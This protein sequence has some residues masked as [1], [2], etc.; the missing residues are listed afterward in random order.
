M[1]RI[2]GGD[3]DVTALLAQHPL[4]GQKVWKKGEQRALKG[5]LHSD[6]GASVI[7]S[8]ADFDQFELQVTEATRFLERYANTLATIAEYPGVEEMIFDFGIA[9]YEGHVMMS[10]YLPPRF[11]ELAAGAGIGIVISHYA[12]SN[13]DDKS[14]G[15]RH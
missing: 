8:E 4:P 13:D 2:S 10:S 1:L 15:T 9:L 14:E 7:V 5:R 11:I 6:S 12:C 3:L